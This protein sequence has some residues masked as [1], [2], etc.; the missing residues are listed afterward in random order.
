MN[1]DAPR[2]AG[3]LDDLDRRLIAELQSDP[4]VA[5]AALGSRLGVTGMTAA[6][7]L[8]R[9]RQLGL[10]QI[11]ALPA[12]EEFGLEIA[13]HG[14]AQVEVGALDNVVEVLTRSYN[15]LRVE[16]ITGEFDVMFDA[17]FPTEASMG[18]LVRELQTVEGLR[19][20]V[21]HHRMQTLKAEDGWGAVFSERSEPVAAPYDL[22]P[23]TTV[24]RHMESLVALAASWVAALVAGD[25]AGLRDLSTPDVT[26]TILPPHRSAGTFAGIAEVE[27]QADRT[28]RT[29]KGFW[30]RLVGI[31]E[32][33]PPFTVVLDA[34]SPAEDFKGQVRTAFSRMAFA[35]AG[36]RVRRVMS[37][38][39]VDIPEMPV[40]LEGGDAVEGERSR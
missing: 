34:L 1:D 31:T 39:E 2:N 18:V 29:Y 15:V 11:R 32:G 8:Q 17:A 36:G 40:M 16:R 27:H 13:I 21:I 12:L 5:Y 3:R 38:G 33:R 37:L 30:Y 22:A 6:N 20:L 26:F 14:L 7:R 23:G 25:H 19:R 28:H 35:F 4:R 24:P 9:L 10:L